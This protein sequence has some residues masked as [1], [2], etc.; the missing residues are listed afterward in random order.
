M[1]NPIS[2]PLV[3]NID[4]DA[5][6]ADVV[7][8][9]DG[10]SA[11]TV[12]INRPA[13]RNAFSASVIRAL[14]QAFETLRAQEHIRI[15]FVRGAGGVF[16]AGAD[17]DWMR[18][19]AVLTEADNHADALEL[20][21]MLKALHDLPALTVALVE[22]AAFGGGAGLAAACDLAIAT[23]DARFSF[24]EAKLGLTPA[25]ISPY[26]VAAV[27][28][29]VARGLF[30]TARIFDAAEAER[31]GLVTS[32]VPDGA[33]LE[34]ERDRLKADIRACAPGAVNAAKRLVDLVAGRPV[35]HGLMEETAR[36]I[37]KARVG[38]EGREG[39]AAFLE[40]RKPR[41]ARED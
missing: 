25:T 40:R 39:V 14:A 6:S 12:L 9:G 19:A 34:A 15:V 38:D 10:G 29:R 1:P 4:S 27:G 20:A 11:A 16:C 31:I 28:P 33:A 35:D 2:D 32:V 18:E 7:I 37:A 22:G 13:K 17:L 23:A 21:R 8:E 26:V 5:L 30:A 3:E 24:S 41:W 36:R